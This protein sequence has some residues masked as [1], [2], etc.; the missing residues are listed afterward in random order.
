MPVSSSTDSSDFTILRCEF[1]G[2][3]QQIDQDL[4]Q[5]QRISIDLFMFNWIL[6]ENF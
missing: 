3:V 5:L 2:I 6:A 4:P 1:D